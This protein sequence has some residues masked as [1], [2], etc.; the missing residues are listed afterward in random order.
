[1]PA[2]L[3]LSTDQFKCTRTMHEGGERRAKRS[4]RG[5]PTSHTALVITLIPVS[6]TEKHQNA[7]GID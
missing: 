2:S 4:E 5:G 6:Q 1:M 3:K 7:Q